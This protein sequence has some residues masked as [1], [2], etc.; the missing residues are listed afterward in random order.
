VLVDFWATWCPPCRK[1]NPEIEKLASSRA[2]MLITAKVDTDVLG[3]VAGRFG[4]RS[5]P[6]M[7]L[8]RGGREA[9]RISGAM[10]ASTIASELAL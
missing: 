8:F 7:I 5:V 4:I 3:E 2:G 9:K 6:T 10:P 1:L